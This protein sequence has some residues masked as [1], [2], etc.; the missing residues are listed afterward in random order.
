MGTQ[1]FGLFSDE[2]CVAAQFY[3]AAEAEQA[4]ETDYS[5][6]DGLEVKAVCPW[7]KEQPAESCEEC[8]EEEE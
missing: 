1:E 5:P 6:E 3:S 2:G 4:I 8:N 7:H